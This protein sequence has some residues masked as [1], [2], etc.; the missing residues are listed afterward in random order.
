MIR[1]C[2]SL[3]LAGEVA[4]ACYLAATNRISM[5]LIALGSLCLVSVSIAAADFATTMVDLADF[6]LGELSGGE[7]DGAGSEKPAH[8]RFLVLTDGR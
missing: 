8:P 6:R 7:N 4:G 3:I 1:W 5:W 2:A